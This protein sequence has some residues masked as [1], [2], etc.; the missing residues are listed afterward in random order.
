MAQKV[1]RH[2]TVTRPSADDLKRLCYDGV[3]DVTAFAVTHK[4]KL[5]YT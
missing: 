4:Q 2:D 5:D 1:I 3:C